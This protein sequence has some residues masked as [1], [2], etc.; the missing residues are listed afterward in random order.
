MTVALGIFVATKILV[1]AQTYASVTP[2]APR[3]D[4][5]NYDQDL[6][7][8]TYNKAIIPVSFTS[9][10]CTSVALVAE[11]ATV[12]SYNNSQWTT[13]SSGTHGTYSS[14]IPASASNL[15]QK[16]YITLP[17]LS[18]ST[19]YNVR[20]GAKC[21]SSSP[22]GSLAYTANNNFT[23][24]TAPSITFSGRAIFQSGDAGGSIENNTL[25]TQKVINLQNTGSNAD[26]F[27]TTLPV[28]PETRCGLRGS[29][30]AYPENKLPNTLPTTLDTPLAVNETKYIVAACVTKELIPGPFAWSY[31]TVS[32]G[33][34]N[35]NRS[36]VNPL[37]AEVQDTV[38]I[39]APIACSDSDSGMNTSTKGV[40]TGTYAGAVTSYIAIYGQEPNP[41]TPKSTT[42]K[43]STFNDHCATTAQLNEAYCDANGKLHSIGLSCAN[44]CNDGVCIAPPSFSN[45]SLIGHWK[46]D[47]NG[48]NEVNNGQS[49]VTVGN[50]NF[51]T[52]GG[53]LGGYLYIPTNADYAKIPYSNI[54]DLPDSFT[55]EFWFRQRAN[56]S[57]L[58]DLVYKGT[59]INNY[60]FRIFRQ[61]WNENNFGPIIAGHTAA[62]TGYWTQP[63]NPNQLAH[64]VWHHVMFTKDSSLHAY[65]LDGI[66][67]GSK[68]STD[69][70]DSQYFGPAKT[71][72]NDIIIGDSA[73]DTDIDNLRIYNYALSA[74][75][76]LQN[77][78]FPQPVPPPP[79]AAAPEP[80]NDE[81]GVWAQVDIATGQVLSSAIC[82]R[83]VCG[84]NGEY[85]GYVP[86]PTFSTGSVWWPTSKRY[87]WQLSGQA[88]YGSGTFN[89]NTYAFTVQGGT[90]Y[91]G[92]FTKTPSPSIETSTSTIPITIS[93]PNSTPT[94]TPTPT[95]S[96][97]T[98]P[99]QIIPSNNNPT[100]SAHG[101]NPANQ[102]STPSQPTDLSISGA[103]CTRYF[104]TTKSILDS[105]ERYVKNIKQKMRGA[106]KNYVNFDSVTA[107]LANADNALR[108]ARDLI[109]KRECSQPALQSIRDK[110][111]DI[112]NALRDLSGYNKDELQYFSAYAQCKSTLANRTK[113]INAFVK[114]EE[115]KQTKSSLQDAVYE[116]T[117][118]AQEFAKD[119]ANA[120]FPEIINQCKDYIK[121]LDEDVNFYLRTGKF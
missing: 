67:I 36:D 57:F 89:F 78:G 115:N 106:P 109:K 83:A 28:N 46:F 55:I 54:F 96:N 93:P 110:Q 27:R 25:L 1:F 94:I 49:A 21:T 99:A 31:K 5:P 63:S 18:P 100:G 6:W 107:S 32:V 88:G 66:L 47:G 16:I 95:T 59:P 58:Q 97:P 38:N 70:Y 91:N 64:N 69:Q 11:Y 24:P 30:D 102:T 117:Q 35:V 81:P 4:G 12:A 41:T 34:L 98:P 68:K 101:I 116:I 23:T 104:G 79:G 72:H 29:S 51:K 2:I 85:H 44:G 22:I 39:T 103:Q 3:Y 87:I 33:A 65:Y 111:A 17:D 113:R 90:I 86:P 60:N 43:Y 48:N 61:L 77:G 80:S 118:K 82:T 114:E 14:F 42:E 20:I 121:G 84:I 50:A 62:N 45:P 26:T 73:V 37:I 40:G 119:A 7:T 92:I 108:Y 52:D 75:E 112:T 74:S 120:D 13:D 8:V 105:N 53:K 56:R 76:V 71:P 9:Y 15:S 19:A 10:N